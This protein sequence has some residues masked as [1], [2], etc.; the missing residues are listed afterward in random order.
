MCHTHLLSYNTYFL[1]LHL[2]FKLYAA[3][4]HCICDKFP[5]GVNDDNSFHFFKYFLISKANLSFS[6][7]LFLSSVDCALYHLNNS[8]PNIVEMSTS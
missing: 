2:N 5:N 8:Q 3:N 1:K 4:P 7:F 6:S